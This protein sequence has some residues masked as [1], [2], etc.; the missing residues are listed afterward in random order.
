LKIAIPIESNNGL[1]SALFG[2]FGGAPFYALYDTESK[3]FKIIANSTTEHQHGQCHPAQALV[4]EKIDAV[5]CRGMGFRAV[6]NLNALGIQV[7][8]CGDTSDMAGAI[9]GFTTGKSELMD[10][11]MACQGHSHGHACHHE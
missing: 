4:E 9:A 8:Y 1:Q 7:Y 6:Q 10:P 3:N 11:A 2:H 5:I